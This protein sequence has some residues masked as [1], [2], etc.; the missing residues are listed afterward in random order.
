MLLKIAWRNIWRNSRR[1][2]IVLGS[3]IVG[4]ISIIFMDALTN[5]FVQQM[6][7]NQVDTNIG[8]IQIHEKDFRDNHNIKNFI[9][10]NDAVEKAI[11]SEDNIKHSSKRVISFGLISSASSSSGVYMYGVEAVPEAEISII[12]ESIVQGEFLSGKVRE[13]IIG[14]RLAEKLNVEIDDKVVAMANQLDESIGSE[15]FRVKGIFSTPNSEFD[16]SYVYTNISTLQN[17][18]GLENEVHEYA[19]TLD[20]YNKAQEVSDKIKNELSEE[21]EVLSYREIL[22]MLILQ[23]ELT[24]ESMWIVNLIIGLA[25][26]FGIINTMLMTVYERIQEF[27]VLMSIGM[28]NSKLFLM[29]MLEAIIIGVIGTITGLVLGSGIVY[30]LSVSGIDLSVFAEGL[31]SLGTGSIIYPVFNLEGIGT[32]FFMIPFITIIGALYPAYKAIKLQPV[33]AIRYV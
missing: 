9:P 3:V 12:D 21:Y 31:T 16:R 32:A 19:I 11:K 8:H 7:F 24:K 29:I 4:V 30:P 23:I 22:P 25:L 15:V 28:K 14:T 6:L 1:S 18:L 33:S 2:V 27:G 5:G 17:M 26:I 13:I 20:E 10:N